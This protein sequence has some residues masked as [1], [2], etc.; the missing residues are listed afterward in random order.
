MKQICF[1]TL[2]LGILI[3]LSPVKAETDERIEVFR[4]DRSNV[5]D[6]AQALRVDLQP[7]EHRI[8]LGGGG[9]VYGE[10]FRKSQCLPVRIHDHAT[11]EDH[12]WAFRLSA[13]ESPVQRVEMKKGGFLQAFIVDDYVDDNSGNLELMIDGEAHPVDSS[14]ALD[15]A[16][17]KR[18]ETRG[19]AY[20]S[21]FDDSVR[22][23]PGF[24][25]SEE[26]FLRIHNK[27][28]DHICYRVIGPS[29][30]GSVANK[31][32]N[33]GNSTLWLFLVDET[34]DDNSGQMYIGIRGP[35]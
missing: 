12:L 26:C 23:G 10:G 22:M 30:V 16:N 32:L 5:L 1:L 28:Y 7:G 20:I 2:A 18:V 9:I 19:G 29:S 4:I 27:D 31:V 24:P 15:P 13:G 3:C 8:W 11:G 14:H 33:L 34:P 35:E 6:P 21:Q 17:A 25:A